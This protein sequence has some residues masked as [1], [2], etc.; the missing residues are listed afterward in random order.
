MTACGLP[1]IVV[2]GS[3]CSSRGSLFVLC[4]YSTRMYLF[5]PTFHKHR[6][7]YTFS[8]MFLF[9]SDQTIS[10]HLGLFLLATCVPLSGFHLTQLARLRGICIFKLIAR[11]D[12]FFKRPCQFQLP[13]TKCAWPNCC[14]KNLHCRATNMVV[15][16]NG[17]ED[18]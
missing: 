8:S 12:L 14:S 5:P 11:P 4:M 10:R 7:D 1:G 18:I 16:I 9:F 2:T 6:V 17:N 13:P 3:V 15:F